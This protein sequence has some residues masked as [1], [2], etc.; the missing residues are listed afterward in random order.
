MSCLLHRKRH[1]TKVVTI[2][3]KYLMKDPALQVVKTPSL[4]RDQRTTVSEEFRAYAT[5][6]LVA[7]RKILLDQVYPGIVSVPPG[8][9]MDNGVIKKI[10]C[11]GERFSSAADLLSRVRWTFGSDTFQ[12]PAQTTM[13]ARFSLSSRTSTTNL[14]RLIRLAKTLKMIK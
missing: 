13:L 11:E 8:M 7:W 14:T 9:L 12:D 5:E 3:D 6:R 1:H 4:K 2:L 10:A